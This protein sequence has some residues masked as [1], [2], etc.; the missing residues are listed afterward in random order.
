MLVIAEKRTSN[1]M[2]NMFKSSLPSPYSQNK[3]VIILK[4]SKLKKKKRIVTQK[5]K[6]NIMMKMRIKIGQS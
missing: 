4:E 6:P 1:S 5:I 3:E 2:I